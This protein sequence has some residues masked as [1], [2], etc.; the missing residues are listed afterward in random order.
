MWLVFWCVLVVVS[1]WRDKWGS[2]LSSPTT[3]ICV[4]THTHTRRNRQQSV[5]LMGMS[6]EWPQPEADVFPRLKRKKEKKPFFSELSLKFNCA[7]NNTHTHTHR[8]T[9]KKRLYIIFWP[10]VAGGMREPN[11]FSRPHE[12]S[13]YLLAFLIRDPCVLVSFHSNI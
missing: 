7:Y 13:T 10:L 12:H 6:R 9:H 2:L 3:S 11:K 1:Q 4:Y 5:V 8:H